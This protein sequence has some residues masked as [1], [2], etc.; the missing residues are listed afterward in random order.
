MSRLF[1]D[2]DV[3]K[4]DGEAK[5]TDDDLIC[6]AKTFNMVLSRA[7]RTKKAFFDHPDPT[8]QILVDG[9]DF[10]WYT[11]PG[12]EKELE[13]LS[14]RNGAPV[15]PSERVETVKRRIDPATVI[16]LKSRLVPSELSTYHLIFPFLIG[17]RKTYAGIVKRL[18]DKN[19]G[20]HHE[21]MTRFKMDQAKIDTIIK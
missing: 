13:E 14:R 12:A 8:P 19:D 11:H 17:V 10:Q 4:K 20:L 18:K 3:N 2:I 9:S 6:F 16:I 5:I 1:L 15:P 7:V 21:L